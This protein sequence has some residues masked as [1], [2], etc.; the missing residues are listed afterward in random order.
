MSSQQKSTRAVI[1]KHKINVD[2]V[3]N[4]INAL[5]RQFEANSFLGYNVK[6][7]NSLDKQVT[8]LKGQQSEVNSTNGQIVQLM[9][10][11]IVGSY[12]DI[13]DLFKEISSINK[14]QVNLMTL[15]DDLKKRSEINVQK[16]SSKFSDLENSSEV[17]KRMVE[18]KFAELIE[19]SEVNKQKME[20]KFAELE[21][22][23]GQ[24]MEEKL[25][26][27]EKSSEA[28][29]QMM[30][31]KFAELKKSSEANKQ[32][33]E[34]K[35][36][37]LKKSSEVNKQMMEAKFNQF[38]EKANEMFKMHQELMMRMEPL[39]KEITENKNRLNFIFN[40][41]IEDLYRKSFNDQL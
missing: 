41:N 9:F 8:Q 40:L 15:F 30:E 36:A 20:E 13:E 21:K 12:E 7:A 17:L 10:Q 27:L 18:E 4:Q 37:E 28:N 33:M 38:N 25:A 31:A 11:V 34:A 39:K 32:M 19:S 16:L 22:S 35:F 6:V 26:E 24:M 14:S 1:Q 5:I 3:L 29:K 23:F 2:D